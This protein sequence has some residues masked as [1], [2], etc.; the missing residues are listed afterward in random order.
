M[1]TAQKPSTKTPVINDNRR[2]NQIKN[3]LKYRLNKRRNL[4]VRSIAKAKDKH[5]IEILQAK[6][7]AYDLAL[8]ELEGV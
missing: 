3:R 4:W 6:I 7:E 2:S 8:A 5:K 1:A